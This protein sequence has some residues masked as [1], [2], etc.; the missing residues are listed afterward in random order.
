VIGARRRV[1]VEQVQPE[2][3]CGR[4]P[5]K[6]VG[7]EAVVVEADVFA[8]GHDELACV[9]LDRPH[10]EREW[11][12]SPMRLVV[13]DRWRGEFQVGALGCHDYT[14]LA[15]V[16]HF[17]T[18]SR[19]LLRRV[20]AGQEVGL[21]LRVGARLVRAAALGAAGRDAGALEKAADALTGPR[22]VRE[23]LSPQLAALM[24]RNPVRR[25]ATRYRRVLS[26]TVDRERARFSAWYEMFPRSASP[27]PARPGT[28]RDVEARLPYVAEMGFD[29]LYLPPV[30]PIGRTGRKG[31]NN[32]V[33]S[34]PR[35]V[36]SP[37]AIGGPD[38][39]HKALNPALGTLEDFRRLV[40]KAGEWGI[41]VAI[42]VAF[43]ASP[44]HPYVRE[45]PEW[46]RRRPDG[47]VRYAENPPKRYEDIYPFDFECAEWAS[48]WRELLSVFEFW[49]EQGVRIFRVDNP[50]TKPF[51]FWEWLIARVHAE[52]P[53][54]IF[55][56]EAFTKPKVMYRLAKLGFT[57][58][59]TYFA[60]RNEAWELKQY[61]TELTRTPVREFFRP[62]LWPNTPDILTEALQTGGRAASALRLVLAATLGA[63]YGVYGPPFEL[64]EVAPLAPGREEYL[65]SEK[66]ELRHWDL[67]RPGSLR[68]LI[69]R[70]NR[71]RR[72]HPALQLDR[73][74]RFLATDNE[75][76]L[77]YAK[78][79][80]DG[81]D[82]V[83]TVVNL[84]PR[85]RQSGWVGVPAEPRPGQPPYLVCDL[86]TGREYSW[87]TNG[88]N[89]V[90]LD[91]EVQPAHILTVDR[92][93]VPE[94]T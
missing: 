7:G 16:D 15:W 80:A 1:V 75:R 21:E 3:D 23:A 18:W 51:A 11:R 38:G 32:S 10:G 35:D 41:E 73:T 49:I 78:T 13:N 60:W 66:Y 57:Q 81:S 88:W 25:F 27:D 67:D 34:G 54:V 37:W 72:E 85:Y 6:R 19:D 58:S 52:R 43:Q 12:E 50:H 39:G 79:A 17:H 40:R 22:G 33:G 63:S 92:R 94:E 26:V 46:F 87:A 24:A 64:A 45:H 28:L 31:R 89:Y 84:D 83:V 68:D 82:P 14:V 48:L 30:H 59:Y 62:N 4:H 20:E 29:V 70:V 8:D 77:A 2:I 44:D 65:S 71:I 5:I 61:F 9:V 74:L 36:G 91:P 47:S 93:L 86:L 55:L 90:E 76:L 42:D 56:S 53:E 69:G